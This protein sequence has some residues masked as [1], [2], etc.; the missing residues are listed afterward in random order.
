[1]VNVPE[2]GL[3]DGNSIPQLGL[4]TYRLKGD[5]CRKAVA[6]ALE[7]GYN[8]IDTAEMYENESVVGEEIQEYD[9]SEL[10]I[11]SK[12]WPTN[13]RYEEVIEACQRTLNRLDT[14]Y[15][16][17]YLIHWPNEEIPFEET[18]EAMAEVHDRGWANS[19]GVSNFTA[20]QLERAIDV[21]DVPIVTNQ[22]EFHPWLYQKE[23]LEF[24]RENDI[25]ITAYAPL[26]RARFLDDE[27]IQQLSKKYGKTPAQII[28]RWELQKG[29][30]TIPGSSSRDHIEE[31]LQ[32]LD[33]ELEEEDERKIDE[34]PVEERM[35]TFRYGDF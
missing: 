6:A 28:L 17:L 29:L 24:C 23:L 14:S 19:I 18:L 33:W 1:M 3:R 26:A 9:R 4:G 34:I 2:I 15:V 32:V 8:H 22:V 16:D 25:V 13:L 30:V 31:N 7:F 12:V 27:T 35:V 11:T 21:S 5:K 20:E 10:F